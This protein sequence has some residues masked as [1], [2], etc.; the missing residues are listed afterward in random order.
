M[1]TTRNIAHSFT[2][3]KFYTDYEIVNQSYKNSPTQYSFPCENTN[4]KPLLGTQPWIHRYDPSVFKHFIESGQG[5]ESSTM[6]SFVS[7][8]KKR[9]QKYQ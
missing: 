8:Q 2:A 7:I 4:L 3:F 6:H 1:R 9:K 5:D